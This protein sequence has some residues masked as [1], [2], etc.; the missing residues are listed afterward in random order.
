M[1]SV[2]PEQARRLARDPS[3]SNVPVIWL[4][5]RNAAIFDPQ[6]DMPNAL[7]K[8]APAGRDRSNGAITYRPSLLPPL[9]DG[10]WPARRPS[11]TGAAGP[12]ARKNHPVDDAVATPVGFGNVVLRVMGG[13]LR[14]RTYWDLVIPG[15]TA[16]EHDDG[17]A[18]PVEF[19][20]PEEAGIVPRPRSRHR[21]LR[22]S[23]P[24]SC[25][26]CGHSEAEACSTS[27]SH[28]PHL[29][30]S[31]SPPRSATANGSR[32]RGIAW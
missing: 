31:L 25:E 9:S 32:G 8:V 22:S 11:R 27:L 28:Q 15:G 18:G 5:G 1:V 17:V 4:V 13:A 29:L 2:T 12:A 21:A 30:G 23:A 16:F 3:L 6:D 7:G 14:W 24:S 19:P 26:A 20:H 10:F